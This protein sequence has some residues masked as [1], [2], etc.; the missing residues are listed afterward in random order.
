MLT[1]MRKKFQV[2]VCVQDATVL[3]AYQGKACA[4][5]SRKS[6]HFATNRKLLE[7]AEGDKH[8]CPR[9]RVEVSRMLGHESGAGNA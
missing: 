5:S 4:D 2:C 9:I 1:C 8:P 3:H 6:I 7:G